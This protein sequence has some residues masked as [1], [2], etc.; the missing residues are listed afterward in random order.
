MAFVECG[1]GHIYD[2]SLNQTCPYCN[3]GGRRM[4][5]G[6]EPGEAG[7][8]VA[9]RSYTPSAGSVGKTVA[10]ISKSMAREPV[11]GWFVCIDGPDQGKDYRILARNNTIGRDE[12]MD[13]CIHGDEAVSRE[14]HARVGYDEK[15]NVFH[16]IPGESANN[17]YLNGEPVY[18]PTKMTEGDVIEVGETRLVFVQFCKKGYNWKE[19]FDLGPSLGGKDE[20]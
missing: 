16:L 20:K 15:H 4:E 9:P 2:N 10:A 11:A 1:N 12:K 13:I 5:F 19:G 3:G 17:I 18:I 6:A 7:K 8:T 14:S